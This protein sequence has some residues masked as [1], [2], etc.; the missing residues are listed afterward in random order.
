VLADLDEHWRPSEDVFRVA[1]FESRL[2]FPVCKLI[3]KLDGEWRKLFPSSPRG[4]L[5][6]VTLT[7]GLGEAATPATSNFVSE[8]RLKPGNEHV[9]RTGQSIEFN[10]LRATARR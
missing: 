5:T 9:A 7:S 8:F 3:D 10:A 1:D 6:L 4:K 2:R